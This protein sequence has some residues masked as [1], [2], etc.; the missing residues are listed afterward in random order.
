MPFPQTIMTEQLCNG[1]EMT[2][3]LYHAS[4]KCGSVRYLARVDQDMAM[5]CICGHC[6][7]RGVE[8]LRIAYIPRDAF[9]LLSGADKLTENMMDA[10][11]PH[12]FFCRTCGEPSF[13]LSRSPEGVET[14]TVN[15]ACLERG[16]IAAVSPTYTSEFQP[17]ETPR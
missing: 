8:G 15:I 2:I 9:S 5:R 17:I 3:K 1:W 10:R 4:C 7:S 6:R 14:V 13:G 16:D 12:H 11:T